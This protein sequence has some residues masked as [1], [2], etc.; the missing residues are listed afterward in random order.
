MLEQHS[1][2]GDYATCFTRKGF[3]FEVSLHNMPG[4]GEGGLLN[5]VLTEPGVMHKIT[6]IPLKET[7]TVKTPRGTLSMGV[8]YL[9][10]LKSMFPDESEAI[11]RLDRIIADLMHE[12][13][14]VTSLCMLPNLF[15]PCSPGRPQKAGHGAAPPEPPAPPYRQERS[16]PVSGRSATAGGAG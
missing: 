6:P 11:D 2:P 15:S 13:G 14:R 5:R 16:R 7:C 8:D 3:T 9:T 1:I 4:L 10:Q 12:L